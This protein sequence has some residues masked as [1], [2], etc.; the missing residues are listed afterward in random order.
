ME[1]LESVINALVKSQKKYVIILPNNDIGS[2]IIIKKY[3]SI[4]ANLNFRVLPS[5]RFEF[6]LTLLKKY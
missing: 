2:D 6:Y 3:N 4:S 1:K 5:L